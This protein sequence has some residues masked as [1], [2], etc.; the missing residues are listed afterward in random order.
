MEKSIREY[1]SESLSAENK[2]RLISL[3]DKISDDDFDRIY[4]TIDTSISGNDKEFLANLEDFV[5]RH[6]LDTIDFGRKNSTASTLI[7]IFGA[8]NH[9][10]I[11]KSIVENNGV[12]SIKD[13]IG[14][15]KPE[16][17]V[18]LNNIFDIAKNCKFGDWSDEAITIAEMVNRKG[19][20]AV[21]MFEILL[22]FMLQ[23]GCNPKT[24][25]VGLSNGRETMEVK[26][27]SKS[28]KGSFS[29]GHV[30]GQT[31]SGEIKPCREIYKYIDRHAFD[32]KYGRT[33]Y[34]QG[35]PNNYTKL[36]E[37]AKDNEIGERE[38]LEI[39][40]KSLLYQYGKIELRDEG[41]GGFK[42]LMNSFC[43]YVIGNRMS[44]ES[45]YDAIGAV[46]LFLYKIIERF[47]YIIFAY[48]DKNEKD[49]NSGKFYLYD[50]ADFNRNDYLTMILSKLSFKNPD[51]PSSTQ[52]RTGKVMFREISK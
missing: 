43:D 15:R 1:I 40:F 17:G 27:V 39:V 36:L 9:I 38:I 34:F 52:G 44:K 46:Q 45:F 7:S 42:R 19:S 8:N 11:L 47:N 23:E 48:I 13:L 41:D 25:D 20:T 29:G 28:E 24:G 18:K 3:L 37:R 50:E 22:Q 2:E 35:S 31:T 32:D 49:T 4:R 51:S 33:D 21:G 6:G 10:G 12:M 14:M 5:R 30:A 16:N 26:S